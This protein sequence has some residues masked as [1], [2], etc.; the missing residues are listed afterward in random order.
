M[1]ITLIRPVITYGAETW[2]LMN[3]DG[4]KLAMLERKILQKIFGPVK[5]RLSR[6][7]GIRKNKELETLF[8]KLSILK[9]VKNK[10]TIGWACLA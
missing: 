8:H 3:S 6:E 10:I 1:Y 2:P 7:W 5:D 4:K 9:T